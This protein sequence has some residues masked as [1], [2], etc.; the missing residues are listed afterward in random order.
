ML[1][2]E[3]ATG[4]RP[5]AMESVRGH[6]AAGPYR[7]AGGRASVSGVVGVRLGT[8]VRR[9]RK[10]RKPHAAARTETTAPKQQG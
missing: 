2:P 9:T 10:A 4:M 5:E 8:G 1:L 7:V 3:L 6:D